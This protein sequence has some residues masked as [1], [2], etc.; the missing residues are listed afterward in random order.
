V[1]T[2]QDQPLYLYDAYQKTAL[3]DVVR[4][5]STA[6]GYET[7][8]ATTLFYPEGGG[9]PSDRGTIDGQAVLRIDSN[10]E[11][12]VVH[13]LQ[14]PVS[15][16]V[17]LELD[18]VRRYDHMQQHTAQ[19]LLT[20]LAADEFGKATTAFHLGEKRSDIELDC[21][22]FP[23]FEALRLE[24]RVNE[25]IRACRPVIQDIVD[26][27][28]LAELKVRTRGLPE[29]FRGQVRLVAIEGIDLNT[30]G[31]T[32]VSN[33]AEI[34]V[35]NLLHTERLR[36]GTRLHYIAG[37]RVIEHCRAWRER[38]RVL[39]G[40]LCCGP[41]SH[42]ASVERLLEDNKASVREQRRQ[43]NEL[44]RFIGEDLARQEGVA[45]FHADRGDMEFLR[46]IAVN[47]RKQRPDI[48]ALLTAGEANGLFLLVGPEECIEAAG[49]TVARL[50]EGRGG[51]SRGLFQGKCARLDRVSDALG[52]IREC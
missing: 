38:E 30:C 47:A 2:N 44:A 11:G 25:E 29:G 12:H 35:V 19:H 9:Q 17:A 18:W 14:K 15:G 31:G 32:H 26:P 23:A 40:L 51:G 28:R 1:V 50:L 3:S 34:Q 45:S 10:D 8:L 41:D 24:A 39:T 6:I 42:A 4:C 33:T 22:A 16:Q 27:G 49:P 21:E 52:A 13:L 7:V 46:S 20:A 37:G 43:R 48:T 36:G 5:H